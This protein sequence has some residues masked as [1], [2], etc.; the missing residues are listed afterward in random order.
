MGLGS[1]G[2]WN[3][4]FWRLPNARVAERL[5]RGIGTWFLPEP[6]A[7]PARCGVKG[8]RST[9]PTPAQCPSPGEAVRIRM[10]KHPAYGTRVHC[11]AAVSG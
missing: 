2:T 7:D 8:T 6:D 1:R 11:I 5:K 10:G 9:Q 4:D 3:V